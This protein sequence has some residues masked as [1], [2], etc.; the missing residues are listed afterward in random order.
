LRKDQSHVV[1][2]GA[3]WGTARHGAQGWAPSF[4]ANWSVYLRHYQSIAGP[5]SPVSPHTLHHALA[6]PNLAP[7]TGE[8]AP[9]TALPRRRSKPKLTHQLV[10]QPCT[11]S[12]GCYRQLVGAPLPV[13]RHVPPATRPFTRNTGRIDD[14]RV[15]HYRFPL[16]LPF[17]SPLQ[18]ACVNL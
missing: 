11:I 16:P 3:P 5:G 10:S 8:S 18:N 1:R 7:P 13:H 12:P 15:P 9:N 6:I 2:R 4:A 14:D 17:W